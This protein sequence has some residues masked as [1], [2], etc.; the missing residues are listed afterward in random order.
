MIPPGGFIAQDA[1]WEKDFIKNLAPYKLPLLAYE[2]G[3]NFANGSTDAL[4]T[5]YMA[6]NRDSRM[7]QAYTRYFQQWKTG[8]GQLFMYYNDVG[9]ES[10]YG[11]WGAVESIM[12]TTTPLKQRSAEVASH[13]DFYFGNSM[14]V[15]ELFGHGPIRWEKTRCQRLQRT[16][17]FND[18]SLPDSACPRLADRPPRRPLDRFRHPPEMLA[19]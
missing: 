17:V 2:G 4:N 13:P 5:L 6:A 16:G 7:G 10:K 15:A 9:V 18:H 3:Q 8:G 14:L 1:A 12:Q 11:S 19:P